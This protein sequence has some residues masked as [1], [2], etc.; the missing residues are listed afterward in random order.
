[1]NLTKLADTPEWKK[2]NK[3]MAELQK[4][5]E[6]EAMNRL[7]TSQADIRERKAQIETQLSE[8]VAK[9]S[10]SA[11][12]T[13]LRGD[14]DGLTSGDTLR[15]EYAELE[16]RERFNEQAISEGRNAQDFAY[17]KTCMEICH[18]TQPE[19]DRE[20]APKAEAAERAVHELMETDQ[21]FVEPLLKAGVRIDHLRRITFP[22]FVSRESLEAFRANLKASHKA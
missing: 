19:Y 13:A 11:W 10:G 4:T 8:L 6:I 2:I 16:Q 17:G 20:V 22:Q 12:E 21:R 9:K 7:Q 18:E 1:M 5:P 14:T 15:K 3:K